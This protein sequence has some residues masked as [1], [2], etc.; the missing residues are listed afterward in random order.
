MAP[1]ETVAR[2]LALLVRSLKELHHAV[3]ADIGVR[4]E[5]PAAVVLMTLADRG[6]L[7]LSTLADVLHL[8]LSSVSRQIAGMEREG[9]V[10]RERDPADSRA[11]L[12]QLTPGG[13]QVLARVRAGRVTQ[14]RRLLPD[15]SGDDLAA[16]AA[17]L[18]RFRTDLTRPAPPD[19]ER[20]PARTPALAGRD[21]P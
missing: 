1:E 11:A 16:F 2:E 6:R 3:V 21:H 4:V 17:A 10:S 13:A 9:W 5:L 20:P 19:G 14:L 12:L 18:H 7:R 15:W 8:D